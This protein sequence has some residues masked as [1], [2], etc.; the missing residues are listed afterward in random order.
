MRS[1]DAPRSS[2]G[3]TF[4]PEPGPAAPGAARE[5]SRGLV[6][7]RAGIRREQSA[8]DATRRHPSLHM[9]T[10]RGLTKCLGADMPAPHP[11]A[12]ERASE[13]GLRRLNDEHKEVFPN[14]GGPK[15]H[16]GLVQDRLPGGLTSAPSRAPRLCTRDQRARAQCRPPI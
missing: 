13:K 15:R 16:N 1:N 12:L 7:G 11:K 10:S 14:L 3:L 8:P 9:V 6:R 4:S 5:L 2:G